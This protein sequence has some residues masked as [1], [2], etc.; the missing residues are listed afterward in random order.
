MAVACSDTKE[1]NV[2]VAYIT[3]EAVELSEMSVKNTRPM[4]ITSVPDADSS[5]LGK[6]VLNEL[7]V[8]APVALS[9]TLENNAALAETASEPVADSDIVAP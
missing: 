4:A 6:I 7:T 2:G 1:V 8:S 5:I 9:D 3:S